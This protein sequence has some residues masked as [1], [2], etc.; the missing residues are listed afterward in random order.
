M[1]PERVSLCR[2]VEGEEG[3]VQAAP[4]GVDSSATW[5]M[6]LGPTRALSGHCQLQQ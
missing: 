6:I 4:R 2:T 5:L 1:C 3:R